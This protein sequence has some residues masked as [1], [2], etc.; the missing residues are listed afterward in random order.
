MKRKKEIDLGFGCLGNG[1]TVWDRNR[2]QQGDYKKVAHIS[3]LGEITWYDKRLPVEVKLQI[4]SHAVSE[5]VK[6]KNIKK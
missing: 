1:T 6:W 3:D 5:E 2:E 4:A